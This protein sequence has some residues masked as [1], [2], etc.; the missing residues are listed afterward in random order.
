[1]NTILKYIIL[2]ISALA[3]LLVIT[4]GVSFG[5]GAESPNGVASFVTTLATSI[6]K[7]P[8][9]ALS[10]VIFVVLSLVDT[11]LNLIFKTLL[12]LEFKSTIGETWLDRGGVIK[13]N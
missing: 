6:G 3:L 8:L 4:D 2:G 13:L 9:W 5:W 10:M 11:V 12:R 7:V 1:M